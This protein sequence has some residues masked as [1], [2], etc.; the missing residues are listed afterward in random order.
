MTF[1]PGTALLLTPPPGTG[2]ENEETPT[3]CRSKNKRK[4]NQRVKLD[5]EDV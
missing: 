4:S 2:S 3:Y 1:P 5:T